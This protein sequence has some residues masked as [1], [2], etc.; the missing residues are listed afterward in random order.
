[1]NKFPNYDTFNRCYK[2][3]NNI[4]TYNND[5][6]DQIL[7]R[8]AFLMSKKVENKILT[9]GEMEKIV[10]NIYE[11]FSYTS[12]NKKNKERVCKFIIERLYECSNKIDK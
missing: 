3:G 10:D 4:D 7:N 2:N 1:M 6:N 8:S 11:K 9:N 12:E 5:N